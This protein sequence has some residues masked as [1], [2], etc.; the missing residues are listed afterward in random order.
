MK[1]NLLLFWLLLN[2]AVSLSAQSEPGLKLRHWFNQQTWAVLGTDK[3]IELDVVYPVG[4]TKTLFF[5]LENSSESE[6]SVESITF[7]NGILPLGF[8]E[9]YGDGLSLN[10]E[11][12]DTSFSLASK[13]GRYLQID[14]QALRLGEYVSDVLISYQDVGG[15]HQWRTSIH[16]F[17]IADEPHGLLAEG[18]PVD[19][20][21]YTGG[22][23][24][25]SEI[26]GSFEVGPS[27]GFLYHRILG[28][29][30]L[31]VNTETG[32]IVFMSEWWG[33]L[34][35][36]L[37]GY[38]SSKGISYPYVY[39]HWQDA[40]F[41]VSPTL[42]STAQFYNHGLNDTGQEIGWVSSMGVDPLDVETQYFLAESSFAE[43]QVLATSLSQ[44]GAS[45]EEK[46]AAY[47]AFDQQLEICR[48]RLL[49]VVNGYRYI[50]IAG[51][52]DEEILAAV[53]W[54]PHGEALA[55]RVEEIA[56]IGDGQ[57]P[58]V[59][60]LP[61]GSKLNMVFIPKG[62]FIMGSPENEA[63]RD[64]TEKA[65]QVTISQDFWM[66]EIEVTY[67][68]FA[69]LV[70]G[71]S[72]LSKHM[73]DKD[74]YAATYRSWY[75]AMG[76]CGQL[77]EW[78]GSTVGL[79]EGYSFSLPTEAQWE[80]AYR[81]GTTTPFFWG[82]SLDSVP[83]GNISLYRSAPYNTAMNPWGLYGMA[84]HPMEWCFDW[85]HD[86]YQVGPNI[87]PAG[88]NFGSEVS[89]RPRAMSNNGSI[90]FRSASRFQRNP[91][92]RQSEIGFRIVLAP[93]E[94]YQVDG[95]GCF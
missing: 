2:C 85:Y 23:S 47:D 15:L 44:A 75:D 94:R 24:F 87:D 62:T 67:E 93:T 16:V 43:L 72:S 70:A 39:S 63:G 78:I 13:E 66:G 76:F 61:N 34:E 79:P 51:G 14:F 9:S 38:L 5:H 18:Y 35:S 91:S 55:I 32:E 46:V 89:V 40:I 68:Q 57:R 77:N 82:S 11:T 42:N 28:P 80:Y 48:L 88:Y 64:Y 65:H 31:K 41:Y 49:N 52:T 4:A 21:V 81:A 6:L 58:K 29:G 7:E 27:R 25:D 83:G 92:S 22:A 53:N 26:L 45:L 69:S 71:S 8:R 3:Q 84:S 54:I 90:F 59:F 33:L 86:Y 50:A 10:S 1:R 74:Y 37:P 95:E 60:D 56:K 19:D 73:D 12:S 20:A 36:A 30:Q 17:V